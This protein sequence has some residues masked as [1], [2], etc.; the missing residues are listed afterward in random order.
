MTSTAPENEAGLLGS[1]YAL[2]DWCSNGQHGRPG[3]CYDKAAAFLDNYMGRDPRTINTATWGAPGAIGGVIA[4]TYDLTNSYLS[5]PSHVMIPELYAS[6]RP[7]D[8]I[9]VSRPAQR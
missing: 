3:V 1:W 2:A 6:P 9:P 5:I 7:G 8:S 4:E